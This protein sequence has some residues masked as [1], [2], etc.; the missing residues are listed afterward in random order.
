MASFALL[1]SY[2]GFVYDM[3]RGEMGFKPVSE[4]RSQ[5]YFWSLDCAWGEFE[6]DEAGAR[7]RVIE[8]ELPIKRWVLPFAGAVKRLERGGEPVEFALDG[9]ALAFECRPIGAGESLTAIR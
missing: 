2:S 7:L 6:M 9:G 1:I 8:G 4:E 5:R 3:T